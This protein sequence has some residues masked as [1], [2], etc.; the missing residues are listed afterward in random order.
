MEAVGE[1]KRR[2]MSHSYR[3]VNQDVADGLLYA[4][5]SF[6]AWPT[7]HPC[8][9]EK[10]VVMPLSE[11]LTYGDYS[12]WGEWR[13]G[14]LLQLSP[15]ERLQAL[16]SFRGEEWATRALQWHKAEIPAIVIIDSKYGSDIVDGRGRVCLAVGLAIPELPVVLLTD[17][18]RRKRKR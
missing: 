10:R 7:P 13:P 3:N 12:A 11:V 8:L 4:A 2:R 16:V 18:S 17:C 14:E 5:E 1:G 6:D 15:A 9:M